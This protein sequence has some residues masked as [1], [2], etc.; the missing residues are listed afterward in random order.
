[1]WFFAHFLEY[2]QLFFGNN[3]DEEM[4]KTKV[5]LIRL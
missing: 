5:D 2:V 4:V 3:V 1:M